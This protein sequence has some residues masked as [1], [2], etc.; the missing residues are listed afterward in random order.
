M[1]VVCATIRAA[2]DQEPPSRRDRRLFL[3][4]HAR[5]SPDRRGSALATTYDF[6]LAS[7]LTPMARTSA[8]DFRVVDAG[9]RRGS[10][11]MISLPFFRP[12]VL[13]Y[14]R[15]VDRW[16]R[17]R[18][19]DPVAARR[20]ST[21]TEQLFCANPVASTSKRRGRSLSPPPTL[22]SLARL[23]RLLSRIARRS[24]RTFSLS[25]TTRSLPRSSSHS[26]VL[27]HAPSDDN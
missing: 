1:Y 10:R 8:R 14:L 17:A 25:L 4:F 24:R 26:R 2:G 16:R 9:G 11:L 18:R 21:S 23:R 27:S 3:L 7:P 6:A 22:P 19:H 15:S 12:L 20:R 13:A 5:R